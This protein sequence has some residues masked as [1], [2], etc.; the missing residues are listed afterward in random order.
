[1][2][3]LWTALKFLT[4]LPLPLP[5]SQDRMEIGRAAAW[6]P[7]VGAVLGGIL[8]A[9]FW[10]LRWLFPPLLAAVLLV[11]VWVLLTGGLHLDGL[12]D[13]CDGL[14]AAAAPERRLEIMRDPRLGTFGGAGLALFLMAKVVAVLSLPPAYTFYGLVLAPTLARWLM[15]LVAKQPQVRPGGLGE[16]FASGVTLRAV[17]LGAPLPVLLIASGGWVMLLAAALAATAAAGGTLLARRRLGGVTGDVLGMNVELAELAV[18]VGLSMHTG[19]S[20][21]AW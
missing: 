15:L 8:W 4:A 20:G 19:L 16:A 21:L 10:G 17:L 9:A 12:A 14:G 1:L 11:G 7:W 6:C 13:C 2:N 18:L 5:H 3:G